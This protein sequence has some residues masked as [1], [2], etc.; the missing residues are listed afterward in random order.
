[1]LRADELP[2]DVESLKQLVIATQND[3]E[4]VRARLIVE[5]LTNEKLRFEITLLKRARYGRSSE[6][7]DTQI[8]QLQL[9]IEDLEASQA[10]LPPTLR[11]TVTPISKPVQGPICGGTKYMQASA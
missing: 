1:M 4:V 8:A 2:E 3:V 9:T 11:P 7:L 5:Q 6:Q 10:A